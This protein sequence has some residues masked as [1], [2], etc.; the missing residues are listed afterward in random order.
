MNVPVTPDKSI[1]ID[2]DIIEFIKNQ[3]QDY[4]VC[5]T[6]HGATLL[7]TSYKPPKPSDLSVQVNGH[8]LY[9][10]RVQAQYIHK[11]DRSMLTQTDFSEL[12]RLI[13]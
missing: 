2:D 3:A 9:I 6:C 11:V 13:H 5:T 1:V 10:S 8:T 4:R 12:E 7:P